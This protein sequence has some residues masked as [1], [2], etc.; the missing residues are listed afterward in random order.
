M[1]IHQRR[2][3]GAVHPVRLIL[4]NWLDK[5]EKELGPETFEDYAADVR[6]IC[7]TRSQADAVGRRVR[8]CRG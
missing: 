4:N 3:R 6:N 1:R 2:N 7:D 8:G 5:V